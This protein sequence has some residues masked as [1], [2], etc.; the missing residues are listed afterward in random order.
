MFA[1]AFARAA[2][3]GGPV[4]LAAGL[5]GPGPWD[6]RAWIGAAVYLAAF[7]AAL[8]GIWVLVRGAPDGG[9]PR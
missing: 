1:A 7:A 3:V 8:V 2:G 4:V 9:G 5:P 6:A